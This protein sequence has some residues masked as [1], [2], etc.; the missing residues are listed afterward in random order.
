MTHQVSVIGV[1]LV[2]AAIGIVGSGLFSDP[3]DGARPV[4]PQVAWSRE[5]ESAGRQPGPDGRALYLKH[6]A[7]CHGERGF[8]DGEAAYLLYPKPRDF[9][10]AYFRLVSTDNG[11]PTD[12][13]LLQVITRGMLGSAM[14]PHHDLS[15]T[16]RRAIVAEVRRLMTEERMKRLLEDAAAEDADL[17]EAD[18]RAIAYRQPGSVVKP[19][20]RL[21]PTPELLAAGRISYVRNCAPCHDLD[22][23]GRSR[24]DL[25]DSLDRPLFARDFTAGILKGG[26]S[27]TEIWQRFRCGMQGTPMP[28]LD[29][30]DRETWALVHY[31]RSMIRPGAQER[32]AQTPQAFVA[33]RVAGPLE[34]D[35]AAE[36]WES[37]PGRWVAMTP[38]WW[39]E[40]RVEG[41]LVQAAHDGERLALRLVWEDAT[42]EVTQA[43]QDGFSDGAGVQWSPDQDP[44]FFAMGAAGG[45]VD[46]WYWRAVYQEDLEGRWTDVASAHPRVINDIDAS[47]TLPPYG[48]QASHA[49][50]GLQDYDPL[51]ITA[52]GAGNPVADALRASAVEV[53]HAAGFGTLTPRLPPFSQVDGR[54]RYVR[55]FWELVLVRTLAQSGPGISLAPGSDSAIS[56]AIWNGAAGNRNGEKNVTIWH[57][58][59]I[60]R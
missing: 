44:P 58:L 36:V 14:P 49:E 45:P 22:G 2:L 3:A 46:I 39:K 59:A 8:G 6:C 1:V 60:A 26:T 40:P 15:E 54:A 42:Q 53:L 11:L 33:G 30:S 57:R 43:P 29:I 24:N 52:W 21:E 12:E 32:L 48:E 41:L 28:A 27:E 50:H 18:A 20:E 23:T 56:F 31:V 7:P 25:V 4:G 51:F 37:V 13:D 35:P 38:L 17:T 5:A 55:G 47:L 19:A 10:R 9:S 16:Q 34:A